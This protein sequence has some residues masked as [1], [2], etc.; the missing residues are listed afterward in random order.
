MNGEGCVDPFVSLLT[1]VIMCMGSGIMCHRL[2]SNKAVMFPFYNLPMVMN[3][4]EVE[5]HSL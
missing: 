3:L 1:Y 2:A 4:F 5:F